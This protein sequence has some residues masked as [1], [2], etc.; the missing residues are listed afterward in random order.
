MMSKTDLK[1]LKITLP[2]KAR[3]Y[4]LIEYMDGTLETWTGTHKLPDYVQKII[5]NEVLN[6]GQS[7]E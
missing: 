6:W 4:F 5:S 2:N 1:V 7:N 3:R